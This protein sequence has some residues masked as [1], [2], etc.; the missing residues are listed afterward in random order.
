MIR[1]NRSLVSRERRRAVVRKF[2]RL[3]IERRQKWFRLC[4]KEDVK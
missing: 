1:K 3:T 2:R 4:E